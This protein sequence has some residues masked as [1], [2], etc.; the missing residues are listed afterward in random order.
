MHRPPRYPTGRMLWR[1]NCLLL[2]P[3]VHGN[4]FLFPQTFVIGRKWVYSIQVNSNG[5]LG[6][7]KTRLVAQ[8]Y[9]QEYDIDCDETF[10][11]IAKMTYVWTLLCIVAVHHWPLWQ[12]D[13]KNAFLHDDL[14]EIVYMNP[15]PGYACPK[16]YV[17]KLQK[18]LYGLKQ[19]PWVWF[20]KYQ[21]VILHAQFYKNPNDNSLFI[22]C[23]SHGCTILLL[24]RW[25][26]Q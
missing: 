9:N 19:A 21:S 6:R 20:D 13:A 14:K 4:L 11:L 7:Y 22:C 18:S 17:C 1:M 8:G 24:C 16:G 12:M 25:H 3:I 5:S 23:T 26:D 15:L 2:R 10:A